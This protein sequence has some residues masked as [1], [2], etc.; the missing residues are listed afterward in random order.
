MLGQS[1]S[2]TVQNPG[3]R[4]SSIKNNNTKYEPLGGILQPRRGIPR[5]EKQ[6]SHG[7][8][9]TESWKILITHSYVTYGKYHTESWKIVITHHYV[10][11]GKYHRELENINYT[12]LRDIQ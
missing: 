5:D 3:I 1:L 12:P 7:V 11:Y 2:D 8:H 4:I 10:I 6:G 9:I